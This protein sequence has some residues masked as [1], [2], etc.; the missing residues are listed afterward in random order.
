MAQKITG[1]PWIYENIRRWSRTTTVKGAVDDDTIADAYNVAV[2][3]FDDL[4]IESNVPWATREATAN[5]LGL[6]LGT[7]TEFK[8]RRL[9]LE[10]DL[11]ITDCARVRR[12][13]RSD[14][15]KQLLG[16]PIFY[17][18]MVGPENVDAGRM[19]SSYNDERWTESGDIDSDGNAD[20]AVLIYNW[21]NSLNGG[22]LRINYWFTPELITADDFFAVDKDGDRTKRPPLPRKLWVPIMEYAKLV[23][24]E[25]TGDDYKSSAI[26]R[27]YAGPSGILERVRTVLASFQSGEAVF[28]EDTMTDIGGVT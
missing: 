20:M 19:V 11:G 13:W 3:V 1:I 12:L 28:I 21:G 23:I 9:F 16:Q 17:I 27:R 6:N 2:G 15:T 4:V 25:T 14:S 7:E 5:D 26:W 22:H 10:T 8:T 18:D 24:L